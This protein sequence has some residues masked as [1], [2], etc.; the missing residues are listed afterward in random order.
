MRSRLQPAKGPHLRRGL[1]AALRARH[2]DRKLGLA[3]LQEEAQVGG[4][5]EQRVRGLRF[6][7]DEARAGVSCLLRCW[8]SAAPTASTSACHQVSVQRTTRLAKTVS[9]A[10]RPSMNSV[11]ILY[12]STT[13]FSGSAGTI[14]P[15]GGQRWRT[16]L[17]AAEVGMDAGRED[18]WAARFRH[19]TRQAAGPAAAAAAAPNAHP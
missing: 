10:R 19:S 3:G 1:V 4:A 7:G 12:F 2:L 18:A 11:A 13:L 15:A 9:A 14:T 16:W 6:V 8:S 17:Q 5:L